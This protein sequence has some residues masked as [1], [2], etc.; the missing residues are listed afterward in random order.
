MIFYNWGRLIDGEGD[1]IEVAILVFEAGR[2]D[3][4]QVFAEFVVAEGLLVLL[5]FFGDAEEA[6][7]VVVEDGEIVA[8][9]FLLLEVAGE[10]LFVEVLL[11][12]V[13]VLADEGGVQ[14][15][16]QGLAALLLG[17]VGGV[18]PAHDQVQGQGG[19]GEAL[20]KAVWPL[21]VDF[22]I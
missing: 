19:M 3:L 2:R 5:E 14:L 4:V 17:G 16:A 22:L 18:G 12:A 7:V 20:A 6:I 10:L 1:T 13:A 15:V 9:A 11:V 8:V 21:L